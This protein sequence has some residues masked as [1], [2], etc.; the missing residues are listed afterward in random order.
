VRAEDRQCA[1]AGAIV[2]WLTVL[3]HEAEKIVILP[4]EERVNAFVEFCEKKKARIRT[5]TSLGTP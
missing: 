3:E 5:Q 4:H 2:P 1:S